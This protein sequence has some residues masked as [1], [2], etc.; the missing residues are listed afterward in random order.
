MERFKI[1]AIDPRSGKTVEGFL[2]G[3]SADS[4]RLLAEQRGLK[5]LAMESL[6][7]A[8]AIS[9]A[10]VP[11]P[12]TPVPAASSDPWSL[13]GIEGQGAKRK[14]RPTIP[15]L[16]EPAIPITPMLDMTFQLLFFFIMTFRPPVG[17]ESEIP[18]SLPPL[19]DK[20]ASAQVKTPP[21]VGDTPPK[22]EANLTLALLSNSDG[23]LRRVDIKGPGAAD[24][25]VIPDEDLRNHAK[26]V[27]LIRRELIPK[28]RL[29]FV[30]HF[31]EDKIAARGR[32][33]I[34]I[35]LQASSSIKWEMV[36]QVIDG[37]RAAAT[38]IADDPTKA[39]IALQT[40]VDQLGR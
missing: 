28:L 1:T 29:P 9:N 32:E 3:D 6:G 36:V 24:S 23:D 12:A 20:Q 25:L 11:P 18:F 5:I 16:P 17:E 15:A 33:G 27:E 35:K 34:Q 38:Q 4:V 2:D 31:G 7:P 21:P 40:P 26:V 8:P 30:A 10:T 13:V 19:D 22:F 14:H 37:C 39:V